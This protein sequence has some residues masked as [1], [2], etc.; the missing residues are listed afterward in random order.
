[1]AAMSGRRG[2]IVRL[3]LQ[4]VGFSMNAA[5]VPDAAAWAGRPK[6]SEQHSCLTKEPLILSSLSS[7]RRAR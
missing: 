3:L 6:L 4:R 2:C 5:A 1:M 7:T